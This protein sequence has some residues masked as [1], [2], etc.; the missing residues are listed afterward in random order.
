MKLSFRETA[1][2]PQR[3]VRFHYRNQ[4]ARYF[5]AAEAR[6]NFVAAAQNVQSCRMYLNK[7]EF[8]YATEAEINHLEDTVARAFKNVQDDGEVKK[9]LVKVEHKIDLTSYRLENNSINKKLQI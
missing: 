2:S 6:N 4:R 7:V 3:Q 9:V 8:P 1:I 5:A